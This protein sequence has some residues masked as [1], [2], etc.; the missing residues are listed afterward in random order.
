[1]ITG[2]DDT[3]VHIYSARR[4]EVNPPLYRFPSG[5]T[6]NIFS[7]KL[8]HCGALSRGEVAHLVTSAADG[9]VRLHTLRTEAG[10]ASAARSEQLYSHGR[11]AHR[12]AVGGGGSQFATC[13]E[14]GSVRVSDARAP[15]APHTTLR[16][17]KRSGAPMRLFALDFRPQPSGGECSELAAGG[18]GGVLHLLD[19]RYVSGWVREFLPD[20][21][22]RASAAGSAF[23]QEIAVTACSFSLDGKRVVAALNDGPTHVY[24]VEG[25]G[26]GALRSTCAKGEGAAEVART[27]PHLAVG[28]PPEGAAW[29]ALAAAAAAAPVP[30][31]PPARAPAGAVALAPL[32][33]RPRS[34]SPPPPPPSR[35]GGHTGAVSTMAAHQNN[36]TYKGT[37]FFGPSSEFVLQQGCDTGL[38]FV[39]DAYTGAVINFWK[40]DREGA[41]NVVAP[42][43]HA[44]QPLLITS[45]IANNAVLWRL[46]K[47]R[48]LEGGAAASSSSS[49]TTSDEDEDDQSDGDGGE[50]DSDGSSDGS[51]SDGWV[52]P[53]H[54]P[55]PP[56]W[57]PHMAQ[58]FLISSESSE[59]SGSGSWE[60][61]DV[62]NGE[63]PP[64]SPSEEGADDEVT[65]EESLTNT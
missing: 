51:S 43:P 37:S 45:G 59:S 60:L 47:A 65:E 24:R 1:V 7:A 29:T 9:A 31:A 10:G 8:L 20:N 64:S 41:V 13:G 58:Q 4:P 17:L 55:A 56:G 14:D 32:P 19:L 25:E 61:F 34:P 48:G 52:P 46:S 6:N 54:F 44:T 22:R 63:A 5:H 30:T 57:H 50:D 33:R 27:P 21:L 42:H 16:L 18:E 2:S 12:V 23:A 26:R 62:A 39:Y 35:S 11:R 28:A 49:G 38:V 3:R 15:R 40:A 36:D 53:P